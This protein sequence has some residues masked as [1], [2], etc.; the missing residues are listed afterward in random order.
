MGFLTSAQII[1]F[2]RY[3]ELHETSCA[4]TRFVCH[5]DLSVFP[6]DLGSLTPWKAEYVFDAFIILT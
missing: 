3:T 5:K 2:L 4:V 6:K 1:A